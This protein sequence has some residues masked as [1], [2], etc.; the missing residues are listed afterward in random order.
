M[1]LQ[2]ATDTLATALLDSTRVAGIVGP[3][4]ARWLPQPIVELVLGAVVVLIIDLGEGLLPKLFK[5]VPALEGL[6]NFWAS[7]SRVLNPLLAIVLGKIMGGGW[8][9]GV[10]GAGIRSMTVRHG[11]TKAALGNPD[12]PKGGT[13]KKNIKSR[14][15]AAAL[16]ATLGAAL[17]LA[18]NARAQEP[19]SALSL[20]RFHPGIGI[21]QHYDSVNGL[22]FRD[23]SPN[24]VGILRLSY[25]TPW[26]GDH[27]VLQGDITRLLS[28]E[29]VYGADLRVMLSR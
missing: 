29:K 23:K 19:V 2:V 24:A 12:G 11:V 20:D 9:V 14:G 10:I 13:V 16:I 3:I 26:A 17:A 18:G 15:Q 22:K 6:F 27:V 4:L 1:I 28:T 21:G 25:V 7:H 5:K 8:L